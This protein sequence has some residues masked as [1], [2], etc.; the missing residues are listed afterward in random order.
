M[1]R[2]ILTLLAVVLACSGLLAGEKLAISNWLRTQPHELTLPVF[3]DR[4]NIK[5]DTFG[6]RQ[7]LEFD[8]FNLQNHYPAQNI[9]LGQG[10]G[11]ELKWQSDITDSNG[12]VFIIPGKSSASM[13][14][15]YLATYIW[16][17]R[18]IHTTLEVKSP[19]TVRAW[20]N[21]E[22]IGLK[23]TFETEEN[24]IG[25]FNKE[26][27]L[28]RGKH[29]LIIKTVKPA[30]AP[31]DWKV[32]A[33][34]EVKEPY[35]INDLAISLSPVNRKNINHIM[36]GI[37]A[38][39][40]Q[41][42]ADGKFY[43]VN[44][45]RS[46]PPSDQ[47]E[48][49]SEIRRVSDQKLVHSFRHAR[50]S[51]LQWLPAS[52]KISYINT[53]ERKST[54]FLHDIEDGNINPIMEDIENLTSY[55]WSPNEQ[56][57][58]Y[59]LREDGSSITTDMR[60]VLGMEDRQPNWRNRNFLY[61][62][63]VVSG[64]HRRLTHGNLSTSLH[65][66][67]PDSKTIV[68]SQ[69]F[70]D[71]ESPSFSA[72][73]LFLMSL[74]DFR[75]DTLLK[76]E[77]R[78]VNVR[79][80][81]DGESLLATGGPSAFGGAGENIPQGMIANNY[82][83]QAYIFNLADR[84]VNAFTRDFNPSVSS[85]YWNKADNNIYLLTTDEDFRKVYRYDTKRGRMSPVELGF[86]YISSITF[87]NN[88]PLAVFQ[89][90][91]TNTYPKYYTLN[92]KNLQS[93]II[94]DS[95][96][97][98]YRNVEFGEVANWNLTTSAGTE[99]KGRVYY[100][101]GFDAESKYPVIVYYYAGTTPVG[102]TF[103]GRY[104]F[105]LWAGSGYVVYVLQPSGAIGFGQKFSAAH[106]NNWGFTVADEIIEGTQK[107]LEAHPYADPKKVGCAGA[108]YGGFMTM[109][110]MTRTDIFA[111][112]I[113]HAGIS[114][115][116]SYWGEG[117]WGYSYSTEASAQ[118]FPWNK[119]DLYVGQSPLFFA[120][121]VNTPLLLLTGDS[122]TNVPPGESIQMYTALKILNRPVELIMVKGED[123]HIVTYGKRIKWHN[124]IMAW[125]DKHL[126]DQP[127][128]WEQQYPEKNYH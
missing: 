83:T 12:Y 128:W 78:S 112:A 110:L 31:L 117:Y 99:I 29:L 72:Q 53:R 105:N 26:L 52:N 62:F 92:L 2:N 125:W 27:K 21:G 114:S 86:D 6:L 119:K 63:D 54:L 71:Y 18:Y 122:D 68:F 98:T 8:H 41:L 19:H 115:I 95:E 85:V 77:P 38:S 61:H 14:V 15:A 87:A 76:G 40:M 94:D 57:I 74:D 34:L 93:N 28:E 17:D 43:S 5:G 90:S 102:R 16:V 64:F 3:H 113:S 127:Q 109:L 84:S 101:P 46:L 45:R 67:S 120:D 80:S 36:D 88:A 23:T 42:S 79:F 91:Q 59:S 32:M 97:F 47:S 124:T 30:E 108:S 51:Q 44:Y 39:G 75:L 103:A 48:S 55:R 56:F 116:S 7:L 22:Q 10:D 24:T 4:G 96:A 60:M 11:E 118:S 25:R 49:W 37:K 121:K 1:I 100:P 65:D 123:H 89:A 126:K 20:I 66:I 70:P 107:F 106:V 9:V 104:P 33:N 111:A 58:I 73:N 35:M 81:P 82:D 50:I 69:N 13:Q